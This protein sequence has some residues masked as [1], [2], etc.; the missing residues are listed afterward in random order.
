MMDVSQII[1]LCTLNLYSVVFQ[2]HLNKAR[3]KIKI[4]KFKLK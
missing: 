3:R 1:T 4:K 2:L